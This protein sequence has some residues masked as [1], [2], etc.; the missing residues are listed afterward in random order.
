MIYTDNETLIAELKRIQK[1]MKITAK[2]TANKLGISQSTYTDLLNKKQFCFADL[3]RICDTMNCELIVH[4]V[5]KD[6]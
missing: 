3:K 2:E 6:K 4:I 5:P 1:E